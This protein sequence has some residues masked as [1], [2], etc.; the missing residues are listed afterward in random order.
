MI[1][2]GCGLEPTAAIGFTRNGVF[3]N[4]EIQIR[5]DD[6]PVVRGTWFDENNT[7]F[8]M[9]RQAEA[10]FEELTRHRR[11]RIR[12]SKDGPFAGVTLAV[13]LVSTRSGHVGRRG[14]ER[15]VDASRARS[16][17]GRR[18]SGEAPARGER[19]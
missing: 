5:R 11:L 18:H 10:F 17:A 13:V 9:D 19:G 2:G 6:E 8:I 14:H 16:R 7:L 3:D 15:R 12:A 4:G 1:T